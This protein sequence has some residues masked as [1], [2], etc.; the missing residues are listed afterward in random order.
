RFSGQRI[1]V[2]IN[3]GNGSFS[4]DP[5]RSIATYF[6]KL[7]LFSSSRDSVNQAAEPTPQ[8]DGEPTSAE[9]LFESVPV[10][11]E[12]FHDTDAGVVLHTHFERPHLRAPP[13]RSTT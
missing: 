4:E 8:R 10:A 3:D 9:R 13:I 2:W 1:G 7:A 6:E 5:S 11:S 12:T